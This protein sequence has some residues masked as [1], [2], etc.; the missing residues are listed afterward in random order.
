MV[1]HSAADCSAKALTLKAPRLAPLAIAAGLLAWGLAE[2]SPNLY[3]PGSLYEV[4]TIQA[5]EML[6]HGFNFGMGSENYHLPLATVSGALIVNHS[7][8][9]SGGLWRKASAVA[10]FLLILVLGVELGSLRYGLLGAALLLASSRL[11]GVAG[12]NTAWHGYWG[13]LQTFHTLLVLAAAGAA[14]RHARAPGLGSASAAALAL[15]AALLYRS[16]FVFFPPLLALHYF[17]RAQKDARDWRQTALLGLAPYVFLLPWIAMNWSVHRSFI[18]LEHGEAAPIIVGGVLGSIEKDWPRVPAEFGL[19]NAGTAEVLVWAVPRVLAHPADYA[20]GCLRRLARIALMSPVLLLLAA[21][22][23]YRHRRRPEFQAVG[24]L[25]AYLIVIH[26]FM[27]FLLE[28]FEPL[29]PLLAVLAGALPGARPAPAAERRAAGAA[30]NAFLA[31]ILLLCL[32][33]FGTLAAYARAVTRDDEAAVGRRVETALRRHPNEDELYFHRGMLLFRAGDAEAAARNFDA[34]AL[35]R[36][37]NDRLRRRSAWIG[38]SLGRPASFLSWLSGPEPRRDAEALLLKAYGLASLGRLAEA[39]AATAE[40]R[41][42]TPVQVE[43]GGLDLRIDMRPLVGALCV[44]VADLPDLASAC[45]DNADFALR[46]RDRDAVRRFLAAAGR[47]R[48]D[49]AARRRMAALHRELKG[50]PSDT[51]L[52]L[53]RALRA[54]R[55]GD[56][57]AALKSL[58]AARRLKPDA[59]E[60]HRMALLHQDLGDYGGAVIL[61]EPLSRENPGDASAL[62]DLGLCRHLAGRSAEAMAD[63]RAAIKL[64]PGSL[65]PYLTLGSIYADRKEYA[66]A[67]A[68]YESAPAQGGEPA[69]RAL[70]ERSRKEA[71]GQK[72]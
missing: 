16:T 17:L 33:V 39:R 3:R 60:I 56:G 52:H 70:L 35:L 7:A 28:Y 68:V 61:L 47:A 40:F 5:G 65:A 58:A 27:S 18:P 22:A 71:R 38:L 50:A 9:G 43:S 42:L 29:W 41:S 12:L 23:L 6:L 13:H 31:A 30:L 20:L 72:H 45:F 64:A 14:A 37:D 53:D 1:L 59:A 46:A 2:V 51:I 32:F 11:L 54:A 19:A 10:A 69:L 36:P 67:S 62:A 63:L 57:P 44:R 55:A 15:G 25:C 8:P 49:A 34:A 66:E 48:L 4:D 26:S 24:L 21:L